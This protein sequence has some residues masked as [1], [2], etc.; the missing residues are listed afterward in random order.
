MRRGLHRTPSPTRP[1]CRS[2][3]GL[4]R[5][6][7]FSCSRRIELPRGTAPPMRADNARNSIQSGRR[8]ACASIELAV[9]DNVHDHVDVDVHVNACRP[10]V[11]QVLTASW[12]EFPA[13]PHPTA[14]RPPWVRA[15]LRCS[16]APPAGRAST[17]SPPAG[18]KSPG[19]PRS[20]TRSCSSPA[21][22]CRRSS[23][24]N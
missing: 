11:V 20:R 13:W 12:F 5:A 17:P 19:W 14:S 22:S 7:R 4:E 1:Q 16:T 3:S 23:P 24:K 10:R 21:A 9:Y 15:S 18:R 6:A 2:I 8:P